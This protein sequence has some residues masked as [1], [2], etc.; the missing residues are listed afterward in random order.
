MLVHARHGHSKITRYLA[1]H[2]PVIKTYT[3]EGI[4][5]HKIRN[6]SPNSQG[7][8]LFKETMMK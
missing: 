2:L 6:A 3:G 4:K 5:V 7:H 1:D 8:S